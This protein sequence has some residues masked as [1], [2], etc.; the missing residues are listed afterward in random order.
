MKKSFKK[1]DNTVIRALTNACEIAKDWDCGFEWLTHTADYNQFPESLMV[2]CVFSS[3]GDIARGTEQ[4]IELKL[5][6]LIAFNLSAE[7]IVLKNVSKH[8]RFVADEPC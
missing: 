8:I 5:H 4:N 7:Q 6:Q 3:E 1:L 2:T